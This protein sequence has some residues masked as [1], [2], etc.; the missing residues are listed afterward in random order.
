MGIRFSLHFPLKTVDEELVHEATDPLWRY[1]KEFGRWILLRLKAHG[2]VDP[3][4]APLR[5]ARF[6]QGTDETT[7]SRQPARMTT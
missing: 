1:N 7:V 6:H 3:L 4:V 5:N 2:R